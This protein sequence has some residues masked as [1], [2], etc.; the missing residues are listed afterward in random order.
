MKEETQNKIKELQSEIHELKVKAFEKQ[1]E[2]E[3]IYI[4]E[5]LDFKGSYV[6]YFNGDDDSFVF[7]NVEEC[8]VSDDGTKII[9]HGASV[10]TDS[11]PLLIEDDEKI[12]WG[13]YLDYD[14]IS[15]SSQVISG[16]TF[17]TIKK[18]GKKDFTFVFES[19]CMNMRKKLLH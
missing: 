16:T 12:T 18:I 17:S 13:E 19:W 8:V 2:I 7:M 15:V 9:L 4:D 6:E 5:N 11:N 1:L 14:S 3:R 10:K